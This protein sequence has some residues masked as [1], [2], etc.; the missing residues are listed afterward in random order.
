MPLPPGE[1]AGSSVDGVQC[2]SGSNIAVENGW[3]IPPPP[4]TV[5]TGQGSYDDSLCNFRCSLDSRPQAYACEVKD[6]Q[7][8]VLPDTTPPS[9]PLLQDQSSPW[10]LGGFLIERVE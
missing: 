10:A 1:V 4:Y 7:G 9:Y 3:T 2:Y 8:L 5:G 6:P